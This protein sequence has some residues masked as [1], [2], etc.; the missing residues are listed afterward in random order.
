MRTWIIGSGADCDLVVERPTIS[1]RHCRFTE[2]ADGYLLEDLGSSNGTYVNGERIDAVTRVTAG[3]RITMGALEPIPW[4][5]ASG[6][7]GATVLRIGRAADN[8]IVLDDARVSSH[9]A[10]LII[11]PDRTLI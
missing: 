10:R 1:G 2:L 6:I 8:D 5:P 7:A 3:D 9:H 11:S 4:P